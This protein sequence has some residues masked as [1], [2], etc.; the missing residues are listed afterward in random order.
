MI[1]LARL[2]RLFAPVLVVALLASGCTSRGDARADAS[3]V[4]PTAPP[5]SQRDPVAG[6][7][8]A[9]DYPPVDPA[10]W[11]AI[12]WPASITGVYGASDTS[13]YD[14]FVGSLAE[15]PSIKQNVDSRRA[16]A[17]SYVD[18]SS[19][20]ALANN[21][22][23]V[24][25]GRPLAFSR[26]YFNSLDGSFWHPALLGELGMSVPHQV[27]RDVLFEVTEVIGGTLPE[28]AK[29][30]V[31]EF[32]VRGGQIAVDIP[33]DKADGH[34]LKAGL[35]VFSQRPEVDLEIGEDVVLFLRYGGVSGLY[36]DGGKRFGW[37]E[38]I[39][40]AHQLFYKF[41]VSNG[42]AIN[43]YSQE[44]RADVDEINQIV[45][46]SDFDG[47]LPPPVDGK[48]HELQPSDTHNDAPVAP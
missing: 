47:D 27:L 35:H 6:P 2:P 43:S 22:N 32:A 20:E 28:T 3:S 48:I 44:M 38:R 34:V 12:K 18:F 33:S 16:L 31:I 26:P 10:T 37:I 15:L 23:L 5:A 1:A 21:S 39:T 7:P 14:G 45:G 30:S 19:I 40:P 13:A 8:R 24:V 46:R 36:A 41:T 42:V 17:F 11:A 9:S 4:A 29:A 25:R